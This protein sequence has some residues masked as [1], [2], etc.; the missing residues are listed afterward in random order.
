MAAPLTAVVAFEI[1]FCATVNWADTAPF[2]VVAVVKAAA[3]CA[4]KVAARPAATAVL[5]NAFAALMTLPAVCAAD[6]AFA[7]TVAS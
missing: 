5:L 6:A 4:S 3:A 1:A 2:A 7:Y